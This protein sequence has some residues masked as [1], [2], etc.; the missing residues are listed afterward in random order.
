MDQDL[1]TNALS[2]AIVEAADSV[3]TELRDGLSDAV[4]K[5]KVIEAL[6]Q[7]SELGTGPMPDYDDPW[8]ALF[9][10]LWYQPAQ[11]NLAYSS[12]KPFI[13]DTSTPLQ[14]VDFGAGALA[15]QFGVALALAERSQRATR[16]QSIEPS[17][18]MF[19][20]GAAIWQKFTTLLPTGQLRRAC[21]EIRTKRSS[22]EEIERLKGA[23]K[24]L[25]AIHAVYDEN[26]PR[27]AADMKTLH[28]ELNPHRG[29]I[30]TARMNGHLA[31]SVSPSQSAEN[32]EIAPIFRGILPRVTEFREGIWE[33]L[34]RPPGIIGNFLRQPVSWAWPRATVLIYGR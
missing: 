27:V 23:R 6:Q 14:F 5:Q 30:S 26:C 13:D 24:A 33:S 34:D 15:T 7:L 12:I 22:V 17:D 31:R 16:V 19:Q 18:A 11:I 25:L 20:L 1:V 3:F 21:Q 28:G 2:E 9:Y 8:V 4:V 32:Q 10:V 29:V